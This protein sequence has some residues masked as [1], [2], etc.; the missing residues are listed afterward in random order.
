MANNIVI[1]KLATSSSYVSPYAPSRAVDG[2]L[3]PVRRWL[4]NTPCWL[5]IDAG[6]VYWVNHW[7]IWQMPV[8]GWNYPDFLNSALELH[9]STDDDN[10][11]VVDSVSGGETSSI[12]NRTFTP[13]QGR[14]FRVYITDGLKVNRQLASIQEFALYEAPASNY[15]SDLELSDGTLNPAFNKTT[16]GYTASVDYN[17]SFITVT[18]TAED[19][20][21]TITVNDIEV[22]SGQPSPPIPLTAGT[23]TDI[24]ITVTAT[25]GAPQNYV[26]E[27]TRQA[28]AYLSDLEVKRGAQSITLTPA[29]SPAELGPYTA[30]VPSPS[31][32]ITPTTEDPSATVV[33]TCNGTE[34]TKSGTYYPATLN[35][36]DNS[37][38]IKVTSTTGDVINYTL[39][40]TKT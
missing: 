9:A 16:F 2:S 6:D 27:V 19:S 11:F 34:L 30:S 23:A 4:S 39:S 8:A 32:K 25:S 36:G 1:N 24:T 13:V 7:T 3:T 5:M 15:L 38:V 31:I 29:F 20:S 35:S 22:A 28:S 40:I 26:V 14:F 17:T 12:I 37:I 10:W 18:P 33:V 21:A